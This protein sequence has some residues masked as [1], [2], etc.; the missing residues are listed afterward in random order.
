MIRRPT[1]SKERPVQNEKEL[2]QKIAKYIIS[3]NKILPIVTRS[4]TLWNGI[5]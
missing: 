2:L 5:T 4:A 1:G 3:A